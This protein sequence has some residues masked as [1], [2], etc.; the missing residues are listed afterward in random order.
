MAPGIKNE[1]LRQSPKFSASLGGQ[2][3]ANKGHGF[4]IVLALVGALQSLRSLRRRLPWALGDRLVAV[5]RLALNDLRAL[6]GPPIR[7]GLG[8]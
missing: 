6:A 1:A 3:D 4:A 8:E 7:P 5:V 2:A